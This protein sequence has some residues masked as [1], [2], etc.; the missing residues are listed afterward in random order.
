MSRARTAVAVIPA[1][2][3]SARIP[4]KNV[5]PFAGLPMIAWTIRAARESGLFARVV[6]STD[7]EAI[8]AVARE[9][10]A[11]VPFLRE[12]HADA[13]SPVSE[14]TIHALEQ[15][16]ERLGETYDDVVQLF[17]CCPLRR[18]GHIRE[19]YAFFRRENCDFVLSASAPKGFNPWWSAKLR[20]DWTPV[21][22]FPDAYAVRSQDL[23]P[24]YIPSGAVWIARCARLREAGT[25]Y[26]PGHRY[27]PIDWR[28]AVDI[29]E[30]DDLRFAE[31][32]ARMEQPSRA[33]G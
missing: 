4:H 14:A 33:G 32:L 13:F 15:L 21:R 9:C 11:D 6:V 28:A 2:G 26:G 7:S 18:A 30:P 27:F 16:E 31:A 25:F 12:K 17:A 19:A 8:A 3:G 20:A 10:G 22:L 29:D 23:A 1:R 24:L 5:A